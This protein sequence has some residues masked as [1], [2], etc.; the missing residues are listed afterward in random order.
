ML[1]QDDAVAARLARWLEAAA[2]AP[3]TLLSV[4]LMGGGAIQENWSIEARF[5]D[6]PFAGTQALVLRTD[7]SSTVAVSHSRAH[8]FSLLEAAFDA[9]V[10]VPE[11]LF[12]CRDMGVIGRPF[13]VMRKAEGTAVGQGGGNRGRPDHRQVPGTGRRPRRADPAARGRARPDP[14]H[15]ACDPRLRLPG[16]P[17]RRPGQSR[18]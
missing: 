15:H 8:E 12:L 3:C 11:P 6:G 10:T 9:G 4:S 14:L 2:G 18:A 1:L 13:Y 7:A 17:G 5:A 16:L